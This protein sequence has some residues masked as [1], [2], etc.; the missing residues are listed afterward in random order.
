MSAP[1]IKTG[2]GG[3][4]NMFSPE[5]LRSK[6][7]NCKLLNGGRSW[8]FVGFLH[9][10]IYHKFSGW[11]SCSWNVARVFFCCCQLT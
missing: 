1:Y 3:A 10:N 11:F 9:I 7:R 6:V 4:G 5:E 8:S 2:R